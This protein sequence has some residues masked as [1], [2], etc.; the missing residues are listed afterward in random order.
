[1]EKRREGGE[2]EERKGGREGEREK[3]RKRGGF[4]MEMQFAFFEKGNNGCK[5]RDMKMCT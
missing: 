5:M 1:M 4:S 3:E 2:E